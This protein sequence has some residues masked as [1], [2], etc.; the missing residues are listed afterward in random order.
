MSKTH[1]Q[2]RSVAELEDLLASGEWT[3]W[4]RDAYEEFRSKVL[5]PDFP[6]TFGTV[7]M[8]RGDACF[9]LLTPRNEAEERRQ[10]RRALRAY[11]ALLRTLDARAASMRPLVVLMPPLSEFTDRDYFDRGWRLL[12]WL[13]QHDEFMW[14][15][16]VPRDPEHPQWS[17]CFGGLP[18]FVTFKTPAHVRRRSRHSHA[19]YCLLFQARDGFDL[20]AGPT[21]SGRRA[22]ATIRRKLET[23]DGIP[24]HRA[25]AHYGTAGNR[26][27]RQYFLAEPDSG[28]PTKCPWR[29]D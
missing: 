7:A 16:R 22:R 6:C 28:V 21:P 11:T 25:L 27:W 17:F 18:L 24:A 29:S 5:R 13:A 15:P 4:G 1:A 19:S 8:R 23:F 3:D 2:L 20:V 14:P 9:A 26:E 12:N 10:I